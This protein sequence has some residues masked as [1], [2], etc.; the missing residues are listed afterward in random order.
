[1]T[2]LRDKRTILV[3][4]QP[5]DLAT[6]LKEMKLERENQILLE[7]QQQQKQQQQLQQLQHQHEFGS[8]QFRSSAEKAFQ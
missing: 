8:Q 5:V 3:T 4:V 2:I 6:R 1:M 7:Q